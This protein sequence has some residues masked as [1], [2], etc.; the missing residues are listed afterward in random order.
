MNCDKKNVSCHQNAKQYGNTPVA[1]QMSKCPA[2]K[3]GCIFCKDCGC[4]CIYVWIT[5]ALFTREIFK[6][7]IIS[8]GS[9]YVASGER[10]CKG[11]NVTVT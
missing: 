4:E 5:Y 8:A 10:R 11:T 9:T 1:V 2:N 3:L 6:N 7:K